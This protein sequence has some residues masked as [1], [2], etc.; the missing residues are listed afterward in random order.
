[1]SEWASETGALWEVTRRAESLC[2]LGGDWCSEAAWAAFV[3]VW[4]GSSEKIAWS[5]TESEL[6]AILVASKAWN[7]KGLCLPRQRLQIENKSVKCLE[8]CYIHAGMYVCMYVWIIYLATFWSQYLYCES[9][10]WMWL[11]TLQIT[12]AQLK[13]PNKWVPC[14]VAT[15]APCWSGWFR[16]FSPECA[17]NSETPL[18]MIRCP[19]NQSWLIN[20]ISP[21]RASWM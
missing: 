10:V 12:V 4:A 14:R 2:T 15:V 21:L 18:L 6:P 20:L 1:M 17:K 13:G 11:L 7:R 5:G 9:S 3:P 19:T 8:N 16:W